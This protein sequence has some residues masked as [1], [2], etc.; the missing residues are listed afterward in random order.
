MPSM[1][2]AREVLA[3]RRFQGWARRRSAGTPLA[4]K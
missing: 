2:S 1:F 4:V 3:E